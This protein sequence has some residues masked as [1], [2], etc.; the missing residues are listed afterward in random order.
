MKAKDKTQTRHGIKRKGIKY[1]EGQ[2]KV[3][4]QTKRVQLSECLK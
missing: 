4:T 2:K 1:T 3:E